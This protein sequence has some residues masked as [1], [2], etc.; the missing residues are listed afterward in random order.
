M[1][2]LKISVNTDL[3]LLKI[4]LNPIKARNH[5]K[6]TFLEYGEG[7]L[8]IMLLFLKNVNIYPR[9]LLPPL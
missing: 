2:L 8:E 6:V 9:S 5:I 1:C 3:R 7:A 4:L